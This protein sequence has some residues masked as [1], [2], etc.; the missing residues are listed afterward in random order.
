MTRILQKLIAPLALL[1]SQLSAV[2]LPP[3]GTEISNPASL[4]AYASAEVGRAEKIPPS[5]H[6]PGGWRIT[7]TAADPAKSYLAQ[8]AVA[9]P[10]GT[11]ASGDRAFVIIRARVQGGDRGVLDAKLQLATEPYTE[12]CR[13]TAIEITSEWM[14]YP[15][16][17]GVEKPLPEGKASLAL[18]CAQANQTVEI[19]SIRVI[20]YGPETD[21]TKFP[22]IR[23]TYAGRESDA[24]WRKAALDRIEKIRKADCSLTLLDS[25][26]NPLPNKKVKLVLRRHEFGFGSATP[27]S[28]YAADTP[29]AERFREIID[30][31]FS[32]VVFENDLKDMWW[33]KDI[34]PH[35]RAS[36]QKET[37]LA[38]A[39]L[40]ERNIA[41]RG[42][43]LMQVAIPGNL[44]KW[45]N[46]SIRSHFLDT[47]RQRIEYAGD[48]VIE[49]DAIN[50]PIAWG[51]ASLF[52]KRPGLELLDREVLAHARTLTKLPLWVNEDQLFRPGPQSD[53]TWSYLQDLKQAG[54][55]IDGLGNQAHIHES[56]LPSPEHVLAV[57]DRFAAV[58][59]RQSI[60]EFDVQ[61]VADEE[62][63]ADYT[64]DLMIACFSHSAYTSFL[65][66]GF[67]EGSHWEPTA[68]SW[69]KDWS[70]RKRGEVLEEWLGKRWRTE[71]EL[72]TDAAGTIKWRGFPGWYDLTSAAGEPA[73]FQVTLKKPSTT[74]SIK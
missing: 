10:T 46:D 30:R 17:F 68:A 26:G 43:Y 65:L 22:R 41:I 18:F 28:Y 40:G 33:G 20:R 44:E 23:R 61:T 15:V 72:T 2:E 6:T 49:W 21:I 5:A 7:V 39:W 37:D 48:R 58:A 60:T 35:E 8:C 57:T 50:H 13:A 73:K 25:T 19:E 1:T 74:A 56:F 34:P 53:N 38:F 62:L 47:A 42:H 66:W 27:A 36:R 69:N 52:S 59:P 32:I 51:G 11:L 24:P 9:C 67:W 3:G 12:A 4:N 29:D 70:I 31:L 14:D 54:I 64:R 71:V 45:D 55:K 63:A 16:L